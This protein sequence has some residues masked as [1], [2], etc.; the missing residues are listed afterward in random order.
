MWFGDNHWTV[1]SA[2]ASA[3]LEQIN[4]TAHSCG[5]LHGVCMQW[6]FLM[7][8]TLQLTNLGHAESHSSSSQGT[9]DLDTPAVLHK[10]VQNI[11]Q[12]RTFIFSLWV[13]PLTELYPL[14]MSS[15]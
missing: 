14:P 3:P 1:P 2:G 10:P 11:Y 12:L 9:N 13:L 7:G 15:D 4:I 5:L 6:E 8:S